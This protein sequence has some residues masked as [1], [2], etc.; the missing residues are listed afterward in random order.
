VY[1]RSNGYLIACSADGTLIGLN[2]MEE[3]KYLDTSALVAGVYNFKG[4]YLAV[5]E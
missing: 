5:G 2:F 3:S 4:S 1:P